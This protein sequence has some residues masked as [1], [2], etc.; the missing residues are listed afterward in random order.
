MKER[1]LDSTRAHLKKEESLLTKAKQEVDAADSIDDKK[2]QMLQNSIRARE[3]RE[4][5]ERERQERERQKRDRQKR[6]Q[7]E[8]ERREREKLERESMEKLRKEQ[9]EQQER[10]ER[11]AAEAWRIRKAE[12]L[13]AAQKRQE[14]RA[15]RLQELFYRERYSR[16][17]AP[18]RSTRPAHVSNCSHNGWWPKAPGR[19]ACPEC[20]EIWTY[21]L[22]CPSCKME[23]CPKCQSVIRRRIP[24]FKHATVKLKGHSKDE[25]RAPSSESYQDEF[26]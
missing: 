18:E 6:E 8:R 10:Y 12:E 3:N 9:K 17:N 2:I 16:P 11:E 24:R 26:C 22:Q 21:L 19:T 23:A 20:S 4:R 7:Q 25:A 13:A 15:R 1:R 14:K 5:Q